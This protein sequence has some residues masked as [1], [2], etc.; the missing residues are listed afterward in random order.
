MPR[1]LA[2]LFTPVFFFIAASP[3][4][5]D[6]AT[7]STA[8]WKNSIE[9]GAV[10][11][12]G[13]TRTTT[14]NAKGKSVYENDAWR[15]T[16]K[17]S[18]INSSSSTSTTAEKYDAS[19]K[20]DWKFSERG[21]LFLRL[22]FE[23]DRFSGFKR[24]T[25]ETIGYGRKLVKTDTFE[26]S[27]EIGGGLRQNRLTDNTSNTEGIA[28]A[29]TDADWQ[30]NESSKLTQDLNTEGGA[31]GWTSKSVT[32]LQTALNSHLASKISLSLTHNSQ[33]PA[34][35]KKLDTETAI[36]LVINY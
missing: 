11:T 2:V 20:E 9:L 23:S 29:S 7:A 12:S 24:R 6:E 16:V 25:T 31:N 1:Y 35:R 26:W 32:A 36:T 21:Y 30:F 14:L 17:G 5:A 28:R 18:A 13:N 15:T 4:C 34:G 19:I 8:T 22:S 10:L 3:A 33:V 27:A